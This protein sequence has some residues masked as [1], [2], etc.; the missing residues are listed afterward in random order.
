MVEKIKNV[1]SKGSNLIVKKWPIRPK[2]LTLESCWIFTSVL[3]W[4]SYII[5][6]QRP[7]NISRQAVEA[8]KWC[9]QEVSFMSQKVLHFI[10][11]QGVWQWPLHLTSCPK[12]LSSSL[13]YLAPR[14]LLLESYHPRLTSYACC[15]G[16]LV[17]I[18]L[19][20][21]VR[22][23]WVNYCIKFWYKFH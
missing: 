10:L 17:A 16:P 4:F 2:E 20:S 19:A 14:R 11:S 1:K 21:K 7:E 5:I 6:F 12:F 18:L 23:S 13:S 8:R 9:K 3:R 22:F 15:M